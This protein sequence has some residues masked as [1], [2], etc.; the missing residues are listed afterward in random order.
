MPAIVTDPRTHRPAFLAHLPAG[1][2]ASMLPSPLGPYAQ[3]VVSAVVVR[4]LSERLG[5]DAYVPLAAKYAEHFVPVALRKGVFGA[6]LESGVLECDNRYH[7]G[8]DGPGKCLC[9]RLGEG[10]RDGG[11]VP[12]LVPSP[13]LLRKVVAADGRARELVTDPLY[14]KLRDWHDRV[15]LLPSAALDPHTLLARMAAGERRFTVCL[16][17]RIHTNVANLPRQCR[18]HLRLAGRELESVDVATCQPLLLAIFLRGVAFGE[19]EGWSRRRRVREE[20]VA[21]PKPLCQGYSDGGLSI[22]ERDC[23]EGTVYGRL[24]NQTDYAL[25]REEVKRMFLAVV[26]GHPADARTRVGLAI[27]RL[28]PAAFDAVRQTNRRHGVGYL[29]RRLQAVESGVMIRGVAARILEERPG[30]PLLTLHDAVVVPKGEAGYAA[31]VV[32]QEWL[33]A[34][35]LSPTLKTSGFTDPQE[36]SKSKPRKRPKG[37]RRR[38][39]EP[40]RA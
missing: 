25:T 37:D 12:V 19:A 21:S 16:Q 11:I 35:G 15:E 36:P 5:P 3:W 23:L 8:G 6:L 9:Y 4:Q 7:F 38:R 10:Y 17:G 40:T 14:L 20:A 13:E 39:H 27:E 29:P 30:M 1:F 18:R 34:F 2:D 31:K 33:R 28:Y 24:E 32:G 22:F 26:Y